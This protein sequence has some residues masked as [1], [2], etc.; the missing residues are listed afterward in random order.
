VKFDGNKILVYENNNLVHQL[1][2]A[3]LP[4]KYVPITAAV[5]WDGKTYAVAYIFGS[6]L[7]YSV[8]STTAIPV[9]FE[10]TG[11]TGAYVYQ[12]TTDVKAA[13][14]KK[15]VYSVHNPDGS[16]TYY[17]FANYS[18]VGYLRLTFDNGKLASYDAMY[19]WGIV[20]VDKRNVTPP[21]PTISNLVL[22]FLGGSP[23]GTCVPTVYSKPAGMLHRNLQKTD[24]GY[25]VEVYKRYIVTT[26]GCGYN[27]TREIFQYVDTVTADGQDYHVIDRNGKMCGLADAYNGPDGWV[28]CH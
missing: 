21:P 28:Y 7:I 19:G 23:N 17:T 14:I 12:L 3:S 22:Q 20:L 25:S 26:T 8:N 24:K 4:G 1:D 9:M 10:Y 15:Y 5:Y 6:S 13:A 11:P 27:E 16:T 2:I 18:Y